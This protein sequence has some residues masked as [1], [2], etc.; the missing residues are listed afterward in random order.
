MFSCVAGSFDYGYEY[1]GLNERLVITPITDRINL[2]LTQ[3]LS[4][5]LG[6]ALAG[7]WCTL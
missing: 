1:T 2:T 3:A 4:M 7:N 6:G 5:H